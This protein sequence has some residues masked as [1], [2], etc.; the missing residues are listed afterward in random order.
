MFYDEEISLPELLKCLILVCQKHK[1]RLRP[2][3]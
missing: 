3:Y 2:Q 1:L